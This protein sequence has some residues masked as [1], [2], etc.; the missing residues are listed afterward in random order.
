MATPRNVFITGGTGYMGRRLIP[1]LLRRGHHV[2]AVAREGSQRNLP[3]GCEVIMADV[4]N[5]STWERHIRAS[6]T[7]VHLVGVAHPSPAKALEFIDID[8]RSAR[9]AI[10]VARQSR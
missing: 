7:L 6:H 1:L 5:A 4:L 3:S 9:E 10:R 2:T 8:L